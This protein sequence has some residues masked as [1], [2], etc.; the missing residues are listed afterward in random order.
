MGAAAELIADTDRGMYIVIT[1]DR[2]F[3]FKASYDGVR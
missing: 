3:S 1:R 2:L